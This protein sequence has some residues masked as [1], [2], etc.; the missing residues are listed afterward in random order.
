[1]PAVIFTAIISLIGLLLNSIMLYLVLSRGRRLYHYLFAAVLLICAL[2]DFGILLSM[3]RNQHENELIFFG[4]LVLFP[5][6]FL[7]ALIYQFT[8]TYLGKSNKA[9]IFLWMYGM[10]GFLLIGTGLGGKIDGVFNYSWGNIYRP[11]RTLQLLTMLSLPVYWFAMLSSAWML[12]QAS[13][14]ESSFIK[15]RHMRYMAISFAALTLATI[16]MTALFNVDCALLLPFGMFVNDIFSALIA[17]AIIKHNLLDITVVIKK[18]TIYSVLASVVI[19]VFSFTEHLLITYMGEIIGGPSQ[20]IHFISIGMGIIVLMPIKH[21]L[22]G[23]VD[24]FFSDKQIE[25]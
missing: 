9:A 22:E 6:L 13:K 25:F 21:R 3:L 12:F 16:K 5:C 4:Y 10:L 23:A 1:M 8:S 24:K 7:P 15:R 14:G 18:A 2:W 17:V 19:F 11:D 20:L